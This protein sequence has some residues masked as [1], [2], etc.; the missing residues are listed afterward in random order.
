MRELREWQS[1][2]QFEILRVGLGGE[3]AKIIEFPVE[4]W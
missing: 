4:A 2:G 3:W 1:W